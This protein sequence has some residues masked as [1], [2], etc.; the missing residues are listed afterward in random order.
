M[1]AFRKICHP[2]CRAVFHEA[3][4]LFPSAKSPTCRPAPAHFRN[5]G[6]CALSTTALACSGS[7][8]KRATFRKKVASLFGTGTRGNDPAAL[9]RELLKRTSRKQSTERIYGTDSSLIG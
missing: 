8:P 1:M 4:D 2:T 6:E 3:A 5:T 7:R 9:A